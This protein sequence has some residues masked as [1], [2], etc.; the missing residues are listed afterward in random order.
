MAERALDH[1][2]QLVLFRHIELAVDDETHLYQVQAFLHQ[3]ILPDRCD[4]AKIV[5][6]GERPALFAIGQSQHIA[7]PAD[8]APDGRQSA[9]ARARLGDF[10][11]IANIIAD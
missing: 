3:L 8:D 7:Q 10:G 2:P 5:K 6:S 4:I 11:E 9:A 1:R